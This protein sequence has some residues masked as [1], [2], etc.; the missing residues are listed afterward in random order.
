MWR[1]RGLEVQQHADGGYLLQPLAAGLLAVLLVL[2][3]VVEPRPQR[4]QQLLR[5]RAQCARRRLA[6]DHIPSQLQSRVWGGRVQRMRLWVMASGQKRV[7][8]SQPP[9]FLVIPKVALVQISFP[10]SLHPLR[11]YLPLTSTVC[12]CAQFKVT[13]ASCCDNKPSSLYKHT[14]K[15][16][17]VP[18]VENKNR[19][20]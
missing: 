20:E 13:G 16:G 2:A 10:I 3:G 18:N 7:K 6:E 5:Q 14:Q 19:L 17:K 1:Q 9:T 12:R 4:C 15:P 11:G 8:A